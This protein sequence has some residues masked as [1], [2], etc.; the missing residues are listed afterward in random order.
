[1]LR[2]VIFDFDGTLF[3]S[4]F[5]WESAGERYLSSIGIKPR[6]DINTRVRSMSLLQAAL[7]VK[8]EYSIDMTVK[9]ITDG[10]NRM[11]EDLYLYRVQP[12]RGVR[13]FLE[14]MKKRNIGMCIATAT[15]R[16]QIEGAL[17]RCGMEDYF[18]E[19]FTCTDTGHGKDESYI[20]RLAM[21]HLKTDKDSTI[22][23]EDAYHAVK[24]AK[25]DGFLTVGVY[26][27]FEEKQEEM[28]KFCDCY[29]DDF[30]DLNKFWKFAGGI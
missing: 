16:Y 20:F 23:M 27:R 18:S 15:D 5:I 17:K 11:V 9:E 12:K 13:E 21:E 3:D 30:S 8:E 22:V 25:E 14:E 28:K 1:M 26:D 6:D 29:L 7:Y 19:I 2:G 24:T 4:M 10:I